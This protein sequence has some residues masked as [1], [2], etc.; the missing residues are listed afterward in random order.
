M[1]KF[2]LSLVALVAA[3]AANATD[4]VLW[5][6]TQTIGWSES[7]RVAASA[8]AN[9]QADQQIIVEYTTLATADYYSLGLIRGNWGDW[10]DKSWSTGGVAKG[11]TSMPFDIS[12]A[13][14]AIL[15]KEGFFLMGNG[16]EVTRIIWRD[17]ARDKSILLS[18][19]I[20]V[21]GDSE[22][23]TFTYD[24]L[25]AAGAVEGGGVQVE[26]T[27]ADGGYVDYM[28][29]GDADNEYTWCTFSDIQVSEADGKSILILNKNTLDEINSYSKTLVIQ[30]G[31]VTVNRIK[32]IQPLEVPGTSIVISQTE[33]TVMAGRTLQLTATTNPEGQKVTWTSSD[34]SIA[35]VDY[36]G[37][38]TAVAEGTA[39]IKAAAGAGSAVC[40][41]TVT[42][43]ASIKLQW[44]DRHKEFVYGDAT[45]ITE[46]AGANFAPYLIVTTVPED[47]RI[48]FDITSDPAS[49]FYW[50]KYENKHN[51]Q[52]SIDGPGVTTI[53]VKLRDYEGV[54]ATATLT[55]KEMTEPMIFFDFYDSRTDLSKWLVGNTISIYAELYPF[56]GSTDAYYENDFVW[57][58]SDPEVVSIDETSSYNN[59]VCK[60]TGHKAGTATIT[61]SISADGLPTI[62]GTKEVTVTASGEFKYTFDWNV[63]NRGSNYNWRTEYGFPTDQNDIVDFNFKGRCVD[64][65]VTKGTA[66]PMVFSEGGEFT[67]SVTDPYVRMTSINALPS[68]SATAQVTF[69]TKVTCST[70]AVVGSYWTPDEADK[71]TGVEEVAFA[72]TADVSGFLY[73]H[74]NMWRYAVPES[75]T[76][77]LTE[78]EGTEKE[79]AQLA[80]TVAPA[81]ALPCTVEWTTSD[82]AVATV[83]ETG[84]VT[85]VAPGEA[86]IT[87]TVTAPAPLAAEEAQAEEADELTLTATCAV[88]VNPDTSGIENVIV[89]LN[90]ADVEVY[91]L[92][93]I[94]VAAEG[95]TP[96]IY[97]VRRAGTATKVLV[98]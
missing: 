3:F 47:A 25:L 84:H 61:A 57:T 11:T 97:V 22:G 75:L 63:P 91:T 33:A 5:S 98:K 8:C 86:V 42:P 67:F 89:D 34:E 12:E 13:N 58:S 36:N 69:D 54:E 96:G 1:K 85:Y 10:P 35:T 93:G 21:S 76:L 66:N 95:L 43:K 2:I 20:T 73:W 80:A 52:V 64:L 92:Q 51:A 30:V 40:Q 44:A 56:D 14:L 9:M 6:G 83:D 77:D 39:E 27:A 4:T 17:E 53:T 37:L 31:H 59:Y 50:Y 79:E 15:K 7:C 26:Y 78:L 46:W 81:D 71:S 18:D 68:S 82:A 88:K 90:D 60:F 94:R 28:H 29:Q 41:L 65:F 62:V 70:G 16:L 87:A 24:Q 38:V 55:A 72:A 48:S 23:I 74:V 19:P 45:D 49:S 32:I